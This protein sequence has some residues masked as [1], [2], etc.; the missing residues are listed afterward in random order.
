MRET[1]FGENMKHVY[2]ERVGFML[3]PTTRGRS[4]CIGVTFQ[5]VCGTHASLQTSLRRNKQPPITVFHDC[6]D[7]MLGNIENEMTVLIHSHCPEE[8]N[9]I[10]CRPPK[11]FPHLQGRWIHSWEESH[12]LRLWGGG[13]RTGLWSLDLLFRVGLLPLLRRISLILYRQTDRERLEWVSRILSTS[14]TLHMRDNYGWFTSHHLLKA[15]AYGIKSS[16]RNV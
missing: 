4:S 14:L 12:S 9:A 15:K 10:R 11:T 3:H 7:C 1:I 16:C 2:M 5:V 6:S 8:W 13:N